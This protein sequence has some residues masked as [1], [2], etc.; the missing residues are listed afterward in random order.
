MSKYFIDISSI[1]LYTDGKD[2]LIEET[3]TVTLG[4]PANTESCVKIEIKN[5]A[6][7]ED[8][9]NFRVELSTTSNDTRIQTGTI[10]V[11]TVLID[12]RGELYVYTCVC[13]CVSK[14]W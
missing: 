7:F 10:T 11:S 13:A 1:F 8:A 14:I 5:D 12:D 2:F 4:T 9:E 3:L 6:I